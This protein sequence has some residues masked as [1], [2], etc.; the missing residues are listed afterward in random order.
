[1]GGWAHPQA[2]DGPAKFLQAYGEQHGVASMPSPEV[3]LASVA[4][5]QML[6]DEIADACHLLGRV[7]VL[8]TGGAP[9]YSGP[10]GGGGRTVFLLSDHDFASPR[11]DVD[12]TRLLMTTI[13]SVE[14]HDHRNAVHFLAERSGWQLAWSDNWGA[15]A[16]HDPVTGKGV[17]IAFDEMARIAQLTG[18]LTA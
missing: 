6:V 3:A 15:V 4:S 14:I 11:I 1:M 16:L 13:Q 7:A 2:G 5:G 17:Q 12:L 8:V 10:T 18:D 9:Y